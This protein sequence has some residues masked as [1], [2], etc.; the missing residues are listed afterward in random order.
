MNRRTT[1]LLPPQTPREKWSDQMRARSRL[2]TTLD[3][4]ARDNYKTTVPQAAAQV[5]PD[6]RT[7]E[8]V[9]I[10]RPVGERRQLPAPGEAAVRAANLV[11]APPG[12]RTKMLKLIFEHKNNIRLRQRNAL[13]INFALGLMVC[14]ILIWFSYE[15]W[16]FATHT[17]SAIVEKVNP[18]GWWNRVSKAPPRPPR[19]KK[20]V[21]PKAKTQIKKNVRIKKT[22][23]QKKKTVSKKRSRVINR[24]YKQKN[25]Q[26][27]L[28]RHGKR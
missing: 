8:I 27:K 7:P 12:T 18:Q 11:K 25:R 2:A 16:N 23:L 6:D 22:K 3:K 20:T 9:Q 5:L 21:S 15:A 10:T 24:S 26:G 28:P 17:S 1:P 4:P 19:Y 13:I 14:S